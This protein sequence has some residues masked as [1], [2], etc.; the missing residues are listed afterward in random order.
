MAEHTQTKQVAARLSRIEGHVRAVKRMVE[1]GKPCADVLIQMAAV[2]S[3]LDRAAKLLDRGHVFGDARPVFGKPGS[4]LVGRPLH[5]AIGSCSAKVWRA[6]FIQAANGEVLRLR[7]RRGDASWMYILFPMIVHGEP[8]MA[9]G[10]AVEVTAWTKAEQ[11]LRSN[12]LTAIKGQEFDRRM[13][14][15]FL[16]DRV[17]QNL[18]ALGLQLDLVRMDLETVSP[19][20]SGR[21]LEI[22]KHLEAM[23]EEVRDYSYELNPST[24]ERAG[25]R[26]ALDRLAVRM[27]GRFSGTIRVNADPHMKIDPKTALAMYQIAQEAVQNSVK[28][29]GCSSIEI[30][31]R[32]TKTGFTMEVRDNGRGFDPANVTGSFRGLGLMSME[33]YAAQAGLDFAVVSDSPAGTIVRV[34]AVET[35]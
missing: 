31:V 26:A 11:E 1:E 10:I 4:E 8:P 25:L 12:I 24:V 9:G 6:R 20:T 7:E 30:A 32:S 14:A 22:Q 29:S 5:E 2:R 19:E 3:A 28:H 27:R 23:M 16:H 18:T 17:G 13:I 35:E 21:V 33:H 34:A 15:K